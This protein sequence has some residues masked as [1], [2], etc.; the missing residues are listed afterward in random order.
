MLVHGRSGVVLARR[1]SYADTFG[2]RLRGLMFVRE[3]PADCDA[4]ILT[5]CNAVHTF[6]M[7]FSID[8]LFTDQHFT[9][10]RILTGQSP[11]KLCPPVKGAKHVIEMPAGQAVACGVEEGDQL[12]LEY[13]GKAV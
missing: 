1:V 2:K 6:F 9:V 5:P 10:V 7:R 3:F 4:L 8:V 11:G 12:I 13:T